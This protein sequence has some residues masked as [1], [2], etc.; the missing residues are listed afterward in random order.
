M[1]RA[2]A[3]LLGAAAL[4]A[5]AGCQT[6]VPP[7][8]TP[9]HATA[10]ARDT[11]RA[12]SAGGDTARVSA[13]P[14]KPPALG[15]APAVTLPPVTRRVLANGMGLVVVEQHELPVAD[16]VLVVGTGAEADPPG[17][18]GAATLMADLL[19]E[20]TTTRSSL[21][22][23]D[24]VAYLGVQLQATSGWDLT[25]VSLHTPTAQ[26]DSA[27]ALFAD[28]V[29]RPS[30]PAE[31]LDRRRKDRLTT[32]LQ[33]KDRAPAIADRAFAATVFGA[34]H[35]Y[36]RPLTG[37]EAS[38][39]A[40]ARADLQRLYRSLVRPNNATLIA[41]G[42]VRPDDVQARVERLFGGW[43]RGPVPAA[44]YGRAP[45][46]GA[47]AVYL[48]DKPGAAQS[49]FRIGTV[50]VARATEDYFPLLVM[51]TIL[52]GSF[53]SRLNQNLRETKGYTY[54]AQ[55]GFAMRRAPGPFTARAEVVTAKTDSALVE[56]MKE[57]RAIRDTVPAAELAKAKQYLQ[58]QLPGDF[59]T[60]GAIAG[61]LVPLVTYG[62]PLDYYDS[63]VQR[64]A[65]VTQ[66]DV[67]RVAR[68]YVD[69]ARLAVVIVGDRKAVEPGLRAL[70]VGPITVRE[71]GAV[72]G[73]R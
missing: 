28:V 56:F 39:R 70:G 29:L 55:S 8:G 12:D 35:A 2:H 20:G 59:E 17:K 14:T 26:L 31:E 15:P 32:L 23:A 46:G 18:T 16:F 42:D 58:L 72:V 48:V 37:T 62:L 65:A 52:G 9:P 5:A 60:T 44:R 53:T 36:G 27:L 69:P 10:A 24:Q 57:L 67:Q 25:S 1:P 22:I 41:V 54:G 4:A 40:L 49:S 30:F 3:R 21:Q 7:P 71:V 34:D 19:T 63:Y 6:M 47:T 64:I 43:T 45:A 73:A 68:R 66:A 13:F 11:A 33:L 61:Q 50:G 51:N 38:T